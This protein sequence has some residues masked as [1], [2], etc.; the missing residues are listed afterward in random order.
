MG[1]QLSPLYTHLYRQ[2]KRQTVEEE[3]AVPEECYRTTAQENDVVDVE[4]RVE[5]GE[6]EIIGARNKFATGHIFSIT[7]H[8]RHK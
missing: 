4:S 8:V 2:M 5:G 1:S 6:M 7:F 3:D